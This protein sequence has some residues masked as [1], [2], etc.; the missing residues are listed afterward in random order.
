[1]NTYHPL[2]EMASDA[3]E[4]SRLEE[5]LEAVETVAGSLDLNT[6]S[7]GQLRKLLESQLHIDIDAEHKEAILSKFLS[8]K[9]GP[10][11]LA[12]EGAGDRSESEEEEEEEEDDGEDEGEPEHMEKKDDER[13][14]AASE[15]VKHL[16]GQ[17]VWSKCNKKFP[18]WPS[19][20]YDATRLKLELT[21]KAITNLPKKVIV[22]NYG[23][24][25]YGFA[26]LDMIREFNENLEE[27]S[28][29]A[30]ELLK[31]FFKT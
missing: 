27:L 12:K 17:V 24:R 3:K 4:D 10:E 9:Q 31:D 11:D 28:H 15:D 22:Y 21:L 13:Y 5:I 30:R 20:I 6:F 16:F 19:Y 8:I 7:Y 2:R 25:D 29:S 14:R 23:S 26:P 1:M 18:W